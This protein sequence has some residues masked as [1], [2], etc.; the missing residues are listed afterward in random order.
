MFK[1]NRAERQKPKIELQPVPKFNCY[2]CSDT[3]RILPHLVKLIIP[4]YNSS[5]DKMPICQYAQCGK[6]SQWMHLAEY[7]AV[8]LRFTPEICDYLNKLES[9]AWEAP[10]K[11]IELSEV[12][13]KRTMQKA[14]TDAEAKAWEIMG[15]GEGCLNA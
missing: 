4:D 2:C 6:N 3:G 14:N 5:D 13:K 7:D 1:L 10:P 15:K 9:Q 8:D 11:V 12:I